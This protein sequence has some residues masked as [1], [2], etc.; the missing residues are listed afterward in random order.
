MSTQVNSSLTML[1]PILVGCC[2]RIQTEVIAKHNIPMKLFETGREHDRHQ[3]LLSK[4]RTQNVFSK[5]L[6]NMENNPPLYAVAVDYV[7]YNGKWSWNL[8]DQTILSWYTLF[9]N[10][11]LDVCPELQWSF[12]DRKSSNYTH[13]ELRQ[14]LIIENYEKYPCILHP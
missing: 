11:V 12:F 7:F 3:H 14:D 6:Y 10:L 1:H 8:R 9:G 5:H 13:F 4:G 2:E